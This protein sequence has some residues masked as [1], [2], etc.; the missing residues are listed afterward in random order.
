M[1]CIA[2]AY[3]LKKYACDMELLYLRVNI[4]GHLSYEKN[5]SYIYNLDQI[6][7]IYQKLIQ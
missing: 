1:I 6:I 7:F 2:R 5:T 3:Y 4:H